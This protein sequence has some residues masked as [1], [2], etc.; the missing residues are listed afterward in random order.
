M[1]LPSSHPRTATGL[2]AVVVG[3]GPNGLSAALTLAQRGAQ[4]RVLE[5]RPTIGGGTRTEELTG[6]GLL[7]DVCSAAHPM[8]LA[9]PAIA[10][11][12]L[13]EHGLQWAWPE[14]DLVHLLDGGRAGVLWRDLERTADGLGVDGARW[15]RVFEPLLNRFDDLAED[16]LGPVLKW[17]GHPLTLARFGAGAALPA[18]VLA[19]IWQRPETRGLFAGV[20]AHAMMSLRA[21]FSSAVALMLTAAAHRHGWPVAVGGSAAITTAMAARITDLGGQIETDVWV[22]STDQLGD[23]DVVILDLTPPEAARLL[24]DR[25]PAPTRRRYRKY[26]YGPGAYKVDFAVRGGVPW[27][28]RAAR[29]A[30]TV[31]L[32]GTIGEV[33]RAERAVGSGRLPAAPF[34]LVG[35]Q[36][37]ADPSRSVGDLHPVWTYAHVPHGYAGDAAAAV[38]GQIERFAPGFAERVVSSH[39]AGPTELETDNPNYVGG[40]INTGANDGLQLLLRPGASRKPYRTGI[41]GTYLCSAATPPGPGV[42]GMGGHH[43]ALAALAD[44]GTSDG[45]P[46]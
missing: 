17:P 42:H 43:A 33:D 25:L 13:E 26:R 19:S 39:A 14:V 36:Y 27:T 29:Q 31:H 10:S 3:S 35:Q 12:G 32:G 7:H 40:N 38:A 41:A 8:A 28:N 21:P 44:R 20:A 46:R 22:H 45:S 16:A 18:T 5:G 1:P 4:V 15:K 9:S 37:L 24:G 34:T 6:D 2:R 11:F 30:G 23:A